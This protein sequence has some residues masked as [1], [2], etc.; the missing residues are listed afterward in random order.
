MLNWHIR[1]WL[2]E[3]WAAV[4]APGGFGEGEAD[5]N[6]VGGT[7][8]PPLSAITTGSRVIVGRGSTLWP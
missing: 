4:S 6:F 7:P 5:G 1:N 3:R 8:Q 2:V